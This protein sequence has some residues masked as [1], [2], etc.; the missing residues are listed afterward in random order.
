M[1]NSPDREDFAFEYPPEFG[2]MLLYSVSESR[3]TASCRKRVPA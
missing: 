2:Q 1:L 3:G